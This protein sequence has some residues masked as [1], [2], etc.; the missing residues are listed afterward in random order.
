M[1]FCSDSKTGQEMVKFST[2]SKYFWGWRYLQK[3]EEKLKFLKGEFEWVSE[4]ETRVNSSFNLTHWIPASRHR[5]RHNHGTSLFW[6][7]SFLSF[8][9]ILSKYK[10][11]W[12]FVSDWTFEFY[13]I[14]FQIYS[15]GLVVNTQ[16]V[17]KKQNQII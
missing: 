16:A 5:S 1:I 8:A 12:F 11:K 2:F 10:W 7:Q 9:H 15:D 6:V 4:F 3:K 13:T 17:T 14:S